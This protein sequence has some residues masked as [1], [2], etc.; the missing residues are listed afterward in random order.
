MAKKSAIIKGPGG[1]LP[2]AGRTP[3]AMQ[4]KNYSVVLNLLDDSVE[5]AFDVIK[6]GLKD[7]NVWVRI[8]CAEMI[9][10]KYLPDKK[11]KEIG[12]IG[13]GPI[14][15]T[16]I[17]R[18]AA[19]ITMVNILDE[20]GIE[21]LKEK[22]SDGDFRLFEDDAGAEGEKEEEMGKEKGT[23]SPRD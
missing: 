23:D 15:V 16:N 7:E 6:E 13:G 17:D 11:I 10:K 18:R 19:V 22:A 1:G 21:E 12:G 14:E 2:G 4:L 20:I 5:E 3:K 8:R 9:L